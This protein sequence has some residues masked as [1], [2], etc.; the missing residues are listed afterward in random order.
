M[1]QTPTIEFY[2]DIAQKSDAKVVLL[3]IDGLGG[4][5]SA[6]SGKTALEMAKIPNLHALAKKS[7][8]GRTI[9]VA[10]GVTPGSGPGH[11]SLFGYDPIRFQIGR[12]VLEALGIDFKLTDRDI[13]CRANFC[14]LADGVITDRRAGRIPTEKNLELTALLR[15][16]IKKIDDVEVFIESG[17]DYRFVVVLRGDGLAEG[18]SETDPQATG[19]P[20]LPVRELRPEAARTAEVLNKLVRQGFAALAGQK[21][22]NAFLLRGIARYPEIPL[23]KDVFLVK[24]AAVAVYP[25]YRGLA[26]LVGMEVLP[27]QGETIQDEFNTLQQEW[28]HYDFFYVHIK[29]TDSY[30]EDG[31]VEGKAHVLED[32]DKEIPRLVALKPACVAVTGDHCTP[33]ALKSHSWHPVPFMLSG[34]TVLPDDTPRFTEAE[35]QRHGGLGLFHATHALPLLMGHAGR[36]TKFGA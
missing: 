30:G 28:D 32:L 27:V 10:L 3:V 8:C 15:S 17:K 33:A 24:P 29:K 20:P 4:I 18:V 16:K 7:V 2:K 5:P 36:F 23:L 1:A 26:R 25:M 6:P 11:L 9:P 14:T 12:G 19:K 31:N 13:A 35:I 22:A 34:D 21:P